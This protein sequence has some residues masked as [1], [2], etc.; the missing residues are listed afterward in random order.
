MIHLVLGGARSGKSSY[1]ESLATASEKSVTYL[2]T[3]TPS[4]DEMA[5]RIKHHQQTRPSHWLLIE[6]AFDIL[7]LVKKVSRAFVCFRFS[8]LLVMG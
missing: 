7:L 6:E 4:D 2:A 5:K 3:A 1:A 8:Q